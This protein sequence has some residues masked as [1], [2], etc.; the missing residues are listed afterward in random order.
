MKTKRIKKMKIMYPCKLKDS[1]GNEYNWTEDDLREIASNYSCS[2]PEKGAPILFSH[3]TEGQP[4]HGYIETVWFCGDEKA[5]FC[6][7]QVAEKAYEYCK[8]GSFPNRSIAVLPK[9]K[10]IQHL[11]ILGA[12]APAFDDLGLAEFCK[13]EENEEA[14]SYS[15]WVDDGDLIG[16][17]KRKVEA[18]EKEVSEVRK[19]LNDILALNKTAQFSEKKEETA[20]YSALKKE[21]AE[22]KALEENR[23]K[24]E[25]ANFTQSLLESQKIAP[26]LKG[27]IEEKYISEHSKGS[28]V[29]A[30][31]KANCEALPSILSGGLPESGNSNSDKSSVQGLTEAA[32]AYIKSEA[33]KGIVVD[34]KTAILKVKV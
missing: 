16:A 11:A 32:L 3:R 24:E 17:L 28:E 6:S 14:L 18:S 7:A 1:K 34:F 15:F 2:S 8:D 10:K 33:E 23:V 22:L 27:I 5:L 29:L 4:R 21:I 25:A 26:N 12:E 19:I 31:F 20:E 13:G 9:S 30:K